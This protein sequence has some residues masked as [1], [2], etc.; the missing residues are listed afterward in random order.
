MKSK[1]SGLK[2]SRVAT[3]L[4]NATECIGFNPLFRDFVLTFT[5]MFF[6]R[7]SLVESEY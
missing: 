4:A 3:P 7:Q 6:Y 2:V 5:I 1:G